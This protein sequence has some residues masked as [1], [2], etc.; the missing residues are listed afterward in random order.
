M[1]NY[2]ILMHHR[3][4]S[5]L[6]LKRLRAV[7]KRLIG[8]EGGG[9][10]FFVRTDWV[11]VAVLKISTQET[12]SDGQKCSPSPGIC[13]PKRFILCLQLPQDCRCWWQGPGVTDENTHMCRM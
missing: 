3:L 13:V 5:F 4:F 8:E 12:G 6:V 11:S 7:K 2:P 1:K 9:S 10:L